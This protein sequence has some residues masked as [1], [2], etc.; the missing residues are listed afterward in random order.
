MRG[1]AA[2]LSRVYYNDVPLYEVVRGSTVDRVTRVSS[3]LS[4]S[5]LRDVETYASLPPA[6]LANSAAGAIRVIPQ[7]DEN[8]PDSVFVG[9]LGVSGSAAFDV[10]GGAGRYTPMPST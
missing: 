10:S 5:I 9:L 4:A 6:Y 3:I 8:G 1:S 2:G 7:V